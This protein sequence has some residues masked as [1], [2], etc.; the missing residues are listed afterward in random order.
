MINV[1]T[2]NFCKGGTPDYNDTHRVLKDLDPSILFAQELLEP[3][4]YEERGTET[5]KS[6]G[7]TGLIWSKA[8]TDR[9]P[10]PVKEMPRWGSAIFIKVGTLKQIEIPERLEGWIVGATW[11]STTLDS[12]LGSPIKVFSVHTPTMQNSNYY[13]WQAQEVCECLAQAIGDENAIVAGDFDIT[14]STPANEQ[15]KKDDDLFRSV[16]DYIRRTLNL[17]NCWQL[18]NANQPLKSTHGKNSHIDAIFVSAPLS[19]YLKSCEIREAWNLGDHKPVIATFSND[20]PTFKE[21]K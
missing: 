1:A 9:P 10:A 20:L 2:Y 21:R 16:R 11:H 7:Y 18:I 4:H 6:L 15:R 8:P 13:L 5:W 12:T 17:L 19:K 14:I 3:K